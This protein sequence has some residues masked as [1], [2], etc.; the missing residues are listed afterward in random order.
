MNML[1]LE[2]EID[3]NSGF[4]FG[5]TNAIVKAENILQKEGELFCLG[6]LVH[7]EEELDRLK[8]KGLKIIQ[9]GD[10]KNIKNSEILFRAHG[11]PPESYKLAGKNNN[12]IIDASCPT[13]L[14]I[15]RLIKEAYV[16]KENIY[17]YGKHN[18]PEIIGLNGQINNSATVFED[19]SELET[20]KLPGELTL[21]SQTTKDINNYTEI[22]EYLKKKGIKVKVRNTI[23]KKVYNRQKLLYRFAVSHDKIILVAGR[24]SSNG[25]VLFDECKKI[26]PDSHFISSVNE[27]KKNWFSKNE[28]VGI[29]GAT[30][31]PMW[32]MQDVAKCLEAF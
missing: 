26:N 5:V 13:I 30:S 28:K 12:R 2:I 19:I 20:G 21:F 14:K 7:N 31:T 9:H 24:N 29:C 22:A 32:L 25:R 17:I 18:H 16:N 10:L 27:I 4:C 8:Q 6:N 11:E 23:C 3:K 1:N 15:Q